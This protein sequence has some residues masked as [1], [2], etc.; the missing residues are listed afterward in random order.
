V[1][2]PFRLLLDLAEVLAGLV[3]DDLDFDFDRVFP[4]VVFSATDMM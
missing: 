4:D 3:T 1:R 2:Q